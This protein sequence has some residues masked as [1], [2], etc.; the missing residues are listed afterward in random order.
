LL[1][2][3]SDA[4]SFFDGFKHIH[5]NGISCQTSNCSDCKRLKFCPRSVCGWMMRPRVKER[6]L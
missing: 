3:G 2:E 4:S 5:D 6:Q 1:F